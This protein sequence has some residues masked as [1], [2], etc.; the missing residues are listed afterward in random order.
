MEIRIFKE[1]TDEV[2][3]WL[4]ALEK[5]LFEKPYS[6]E[7]LEREARAKNNLLILIAFDGDKPCAYKA[8]FEISSRI[9][10]SW[11]GGV[12]PEYRGQGI[13][14]ALIQKQHSLIPQMGHRCVRTF[15]ENKYRA[16][17]I[18]NLK[19]GFDVIGVYKSDHDEKQTIMLEKMLESHTG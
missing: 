19:S 12:L 16:M 11:I 6:R 14:R 3:D 9:F 10:Y 15:T 4:F 5:A 7:K 17:L 18:L 8:G 2:L 1:A 13:A